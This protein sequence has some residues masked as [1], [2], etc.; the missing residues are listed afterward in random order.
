MADMLVELN[1][2]IDAAG[3]TDPRFAATIELARQYASFLDELGI[4]ELQKTG[5]LLLAALDKLG[6]TATG[7]LARGGE[8]D[9]GKPANPLDELRRK[10]EQRNVS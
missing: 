4:E 2:A 9:A 8:P 7:K 10:R 6:L 3:L 1:K 5:P